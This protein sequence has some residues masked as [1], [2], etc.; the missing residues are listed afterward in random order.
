MGF[1]DCDCVHYSFP[2][3]LLFGYRLRLQRFGPERP[4]LVRAKG[5]RVIPALM[6]II[7][8]LGSATRRI[9]SPIGRPTFAPRRFSSPR[10]RLLAR[11]GSAPPRASPRGVCTCWPSTVDPCFFYL[12]SC[13]LPSLLLALSFAINIIIHPSNHL[14][15]LLRYQ[16]AKLVIFVYNPQHGNTNRTH[17]RSDA[18]QYAED[19]SRPVRGMC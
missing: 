16:F 19:S 15:T 11:G 6:Q 3:L 12:P 14:S 2:F 5:R 1:Q 8:H 17:T 10:G 4:G 13:S 9:S 18:G 7:H